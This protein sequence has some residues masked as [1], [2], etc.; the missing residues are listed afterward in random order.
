MKNIKTLKINSI[1]LITIFAIFAYSCSKDDDMNQDVTALSQY[2]DNF[3]TFSTE[4]R[5]SP[6]NWSAFQALG[7]PNTYPNHGD[8]NTAWASSSSNSQRE[9]IE[10]SI[11]TAMYV[12]RIDIYE[13]YNPGSIDTVKVRNA[14]NSEWVTIYSGTAEELAK[15]ARIMSVQLDEMTDFYVDAVRI[16]INSPAISGWNEID[17]IEFFGAYDTENI[18][19]GPE[20]YTE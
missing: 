2:A 7:K 20:K 10:L 19:N 1:R 8:I 6:G 3:I 18:N 16:D 5:E 9:F 15:E 4:Y 12:N 14:S 11:D 13:T 17:A